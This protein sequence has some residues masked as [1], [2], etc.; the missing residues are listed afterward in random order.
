MRA[1]DEFSWWDMPRVSAH[2]PC[3]AGRAGRA[4]WMFEKQHGIVWF[5]MH[6]L[7]TPRHADHEDSRVDPGG[8]RLERHGNLTGLPTR[9]GI[10]VESF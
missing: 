1:A 3:R 10:A 7:N 9:D 4:A 6:G 2:G 5:D 8:C